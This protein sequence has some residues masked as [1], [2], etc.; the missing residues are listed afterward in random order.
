MCYKGKKH[1]REKRF[2]FS[3]VDEANVKKKKKVDKKCESER[4]GKSRQFLE[5]FFNASDGRP[6][7]HLETLSPF[8][9]LT[10]YIFPK[11]DDRLTRT[12]LFSVL[13]EMLLSS[14]M[15]SMT[16]IALIYSVILA[17]D[18]ARS[19]MPSLSVSIIELRRRLIVLGCW[20]ASYCTKRNASTKRTIL[21]SKRS[22][23]KLTRPLIFESLHSC[24]K[25]RSL[26]TTGK[27]GISGGELFI[28][29]LR[30]VFILREGSISA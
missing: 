28:S 10:R 9:R 7:R 18:A 15:S 5:Q 30:Y 13:C 16:C 20:I 4:Y 24:T 1:R 3:K 6:P 11:D 17:T 2:L 8:S 27:N 26:M 14:L 29:K 21:A 19:S 25:K 22:L 12:V 23:S